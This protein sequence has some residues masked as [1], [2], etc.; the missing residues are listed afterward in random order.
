MEFWQSCE[1]FL[2]NCSNFSAR[3][4][5]M[6]KKKTIFPQFFPPT[7]FCIS[8]LF[9]WHPDYFFVSRQEKLLKHQN[10]WTNKTFIKK[11]TFS[12]K[13]PLDARIAVVTTREKIFFRLSV[14]WI[15]DRKKCEK[16]YIFQKLFFPKNFHVYRDCWF[17]NSGETFAG[18][19]HSLRIGKNSQLFSFEKKIS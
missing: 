6:I 18:S 2:S 19:K 15:R 8:R 7:F 13:T 12:Q 14:F 16:L 10:R 1:Y 9:L 17:R 3:N 4:P 11:I 5:K